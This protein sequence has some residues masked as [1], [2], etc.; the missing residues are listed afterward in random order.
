MSG[1]DPGQPGDLS[2]KGE[3]VLV[4]GAGGFIGSHLAERLTQ[5]GA[6]V[7]ALVHYDSQGGRGCL[8]LLEP[9]VRAAIDI[10]PGDV[11]DASQVESVVAGHR[12]VFHLAALIGIPYS[13]Q[14]PEI[15]VSTN[16]M[17]TL[18]VLQ[19][20]RKA[21]V[22]R[23]VQTSTSEVYGTAL[24]VPIDED[25]PLQ[26]QSPYAA[27]KI[28]ADKLVE[29]YA[30]SFGLSAVIAR[31]FNTYGPRQSA[32]AVIPTI[33]SQAL[34]RAEIRLGALSPVR[35]FNYVSDTVDGFV[36][37]GTAA[38]APAGEAINLGSGEGHTIGETVALVLEILG[39]DLPVHADEQRVRPAASEV[40]RLLCDNRKALRCLGWQPRVAFR[41]GL[42]R[43]IR[44]I[45]AHPDWI[46]SSRYHV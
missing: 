40:Q 23:L 35:D 20:C 5:D 2:L 12:V 30:K 3:R 44:W 22:E 21:G 27:T 39:K 36:R 11:L 4:T 18:N 31:P 42:E 19:A 15:Y 33:I 7:T 29:S 6:R 28:G 26:A 46:E 34:S 24:R 16:V 9:Y 10:V 13:Y 38:T 14:A 43:T 8:D 45:E 32:R 17:G 41:E 1:L 25:H 37:A